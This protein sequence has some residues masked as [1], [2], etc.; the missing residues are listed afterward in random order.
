MQ[1]RNQL[2]LS[3][4][5]PHNYNWGSNDENQSEQPSQE[6][7]PTTND[8]DDV[9]NTL[10][11]NRWSKFAPDANLSTDEFRSQLRENMKGR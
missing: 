9:D 5:P 11:A 1:Q 6:N 3:Q 7:T 10:K 8:N 4:S 2:T